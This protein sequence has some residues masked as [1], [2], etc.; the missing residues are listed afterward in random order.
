MD[1]HA[2]SSPRNREV[3]SWILSLLL[4]G[5]LALFLAFLPS[6]N[7]HEDK[8]PPIEIVKRDPPPLKERKQELEP[9]LQNEDQV[10]TLSKTPRIRP[11]LPKRSQ[12]P[13]HE[14][15]PENAPPE[16]EDTGPR[17]F[18]ITMSG[19][20][21]AA[22]GTGVQVPVGDSLA[23]SP[24]ITKRGEKKERPKEEKKG[25]KLDYA[26][27]EEA[28]AA[29]LT[30]QPKLLRKITPEYPE[31]MKELGIEGRVFVEVTVD[32]KGKVVEAKLLK[33]LHPDLDAVA[34]AAARTLIFSP[35][36]INGKS[37]K[38]KIPVPF[39]FVLD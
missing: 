19:T 18:G 2:M 33:G 8:L 4:H 25:F 35:A 36:T 13:P 17:T 9:A 28:P 15:P 32:E 31:K 10:A 20:T 30:T 1:R 5:G 21:T 37:V 12:T 29:V 34:L 39:A 16:I 3:F 38:T 11:A 26:R 22:P 23:V 6:E 7:G 14:K 24:R 27:G